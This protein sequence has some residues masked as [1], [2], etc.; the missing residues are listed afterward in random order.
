MA[1]QGN[2]KSGGGGAPIRIPTDPSE[3]QAFFMQ[4]VQIG[5]ELLQEG[6]FSR[7]LEYIIYNT[8][9]LILNLF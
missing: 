6:V 9:F 5:E 4:E 8:V 1:R 7:I 3:W 2:T